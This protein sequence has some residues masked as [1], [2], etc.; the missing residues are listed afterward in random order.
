MYE[1]TI[2]NYLANQLFWQVIWKISDGNHS[3]IAINFYS[4]FFRSLVSNLD[5][6][7]KS[8]LAYLRI[9]LI[10]PE[11]WRFSRWMVTKEFIHE[12]CRFEL[13]FTG[14]QESERGQRYLGVYAGYT[15]RLP[16]PGSEVL[17]QNVARCSRSCLK[18]DIFEG[19]HL[20]LFLGCIGLIKP[21]FLSC[22]ILRIHC[23]IEMTW[24]HCICTKKT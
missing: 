2:L 17:N 3:D 8:L 16:Q 22:R 23:L 7:T 11:N 14:I 4:L 9:C 10:L 19:K 24:K 21:I 13:P 1:I 12:W 6:V 5:Y 18:N 20:P 15:S